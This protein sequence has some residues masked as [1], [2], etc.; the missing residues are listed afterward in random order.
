M[1]TDELKYKYIDDLYE[2]LTALSKN[3]DNP[4]HQIFLVKNKRT[5]KIAVKKLISLHA[6]P[7]YEKLKELSS[8]H[9]ATIYECVYNDRSGIVIE[10][11][12][13]GDTLQEH[14]TQSGVL[15][16][17]ETLKI[18]SDLCDILRI[19]HK[20][21]IVHRDLTPENIILSNDGV[22]KLIDFGIAR[23][24]KESQPQDT[25]LLGTVGYAAPEQFGFSQTD[26][27]TDIYALGV[28]MNKLLTG[29]FPSEHLC[30]RAKWK[31]IIQKCTEMDARQ[32]YQSVAELQRSLC[33]AF[34][35]H[36]AHSE[37][38][39]FWLPGFRSGVLWKSIVAVLGYGA[40]L[41]YTITSLE[42][43]AASPKAFLLEYAA[44]LLYLWGNTLIALNI[45]NWDKKLYPFRKFHPK[46]NL[47]IRVVLWFVLFYLGIL[48]ENHVRYDILGLPRPSN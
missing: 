23:E 32:R 35:F 20:E 13:N 46:I 41:I 34:P 17:D 29:S 30:D 42:S 43:A 25:V 18:I 15:S 33:K 10:E 39:V 45:A 5:G 1:D 38:Y 3:E 40:M 19:I 12:V 28:L 9:L 48:L 31:R 44:L 4:E 47:T 6:V 2:N 16:E 36:A 22:L 11:F 24:S 37:E 27:R 26:A 7:I 14:M 8:P 21:G